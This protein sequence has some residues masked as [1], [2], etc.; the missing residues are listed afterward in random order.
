[1]KGEVDKFHFEMGPPC[2]PKKEA[3]TGILRN[4]TPSPDRQ[5]GWSRPCPVTAKR[6][7]TP[8]STRRP[9]SPSWPS[10]RWRSS[11][12]PTDSSVKR[13]YNTWA[14]EL[15][16]PGRHGFDTVI[17]GRRRIIDSRRDFPRAVGAACE[18]WQRGESHERLQKRQ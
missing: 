17:F 15:T 1:M 4:A 5:A 16:H 14:D 3:A 9:R 7:S 13:E 18:A 11:S 12:T 8:F 10:P 6:V 2:A